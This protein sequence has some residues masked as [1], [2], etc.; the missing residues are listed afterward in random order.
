MNLF[1]IKVP[2]DSISMVFDTFNGAEN[3]NTSLYL[4]KSKIILKEP[5]NKYSAKLEIDLDQDLKKNKLVRQTF[6]KEYGTYLITFLNADFSTAEKAYYSFFIYY[7]LEGFDN[8]FPN[9]AE[10]FPIEYSTRYIS[11]KNFW[12]Y[13]NKCFDYSKDKYIK[14]QND[15]RKT[16][17]FVFTLNDFNNELNVDR[18]SKFVAFSNY[19]DLIGQFKT[20][21]SFSIMST[22]EYKTKNI[23]EIEELANTIVNKESRIGNFIFIRVFISFCII[24]YS[25]I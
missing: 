12:N 19:V 20:R 18:Y 1:N 23:K 10:V 8:L 25:I 11:Q 16:I 22:N 5:D 14:F 15:L 24:L 6:N 7:G 2:K 4:Y 9:M 3:Y 13:Y 17:D 21:I